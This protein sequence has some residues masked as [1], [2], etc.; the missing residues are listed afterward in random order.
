MCSTDN[1]NNNNY[2]SLQLRENSFLRGRILLKMY[3]F[4]SVV[5]VLLFKYIVIACACS[6]SSDC[7]WVVEAAWRGLDVQVSEGEPN[8]EALRN[9]QDPLLQ[10]I[11]A[12][13]LRVLG[14][15]NIPIHQWLWADQPQA[16]RQTQEPEK[17]CT[18]REFDLF[19]R[20][21]DLVQS[22]CKVTDESNTNS[23]CSS[24]KTL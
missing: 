10:Q 20:F 11:G 9:S 21:I 5:P 14:G 15:D 1:P 16:C 8:L 24:C 23:Y 4:K 22:W 7:E 2:Y 18:N 6:C 17:K 13:G 12:V 3:L 19:I